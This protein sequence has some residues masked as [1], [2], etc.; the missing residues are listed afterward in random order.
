M[1]DE[2]WPDP[3]RWY[4]EAEGSLG[5]GLDFDQQGDEFEGEDEYEDGEEPLGDEQAMGDEEVEI[6]EEH[7]GELAPSSVTDWPCSSNDRWCNVR[8][9]LSIACKLANCYA[10]IVAGMRH[11]QFRTCLQEPSGQQPQTL[12]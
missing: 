6:I 10:H 7:D 5:A 3:L 8:F 1:K 9:C 11:L 12:D 2:I 4:R